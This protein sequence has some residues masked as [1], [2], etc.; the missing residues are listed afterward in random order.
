MSSSTKGIMNRARKKTKG[1]RQRLRQKN[2]R[3]GEEPKGRKEGRRRVC[4]KRRE[5]DTQTR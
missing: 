4:G 1:K 2:E 5:K 3:E